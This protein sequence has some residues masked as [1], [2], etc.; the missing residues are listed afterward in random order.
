MR[1]PL[2]AFAAQHPTRNL[3]TW[4]IW[5]GPIPDRP[6]W[7]LTAS[8]HTP[9]SLLAN[10]ADN[11]AHGTGTRQAQITGSE[12]KASLSTRSPAIPGGAA[13]HATSH[14]R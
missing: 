9:S 8:P 4:T 3:A 11:L 13:G 5:A 1:C 2:S 12:R 6:T 14:T 7:T 10:L